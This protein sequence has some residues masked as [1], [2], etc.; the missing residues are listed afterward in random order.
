MLAEAPGY[1]SFDETSQEYFYEEMP[2]KYT[3]LSGV[4]G[5]VQDIVPESSVLIKTKVTEIDL[6]AATN[7]FA[8]GELVVFPNP[9]E[10]L[11]KY[12]LENF[13]KTTQGKI[14]YVGHNADL[15]IM[16]KANDLKISAVIAGSAD[17]ASFSYAKS[18]NLGLGVLSGFGKLETPD[19]IYRLINSVAYRHVFFHGDLGVLR[20]PM[21][22]NEGKLS[23]EKTQPVLKRKALPKVVKK[24]V[25][26]QVVQVLQ[27]PHFGKI[28]LID[29]VTGSSIFVRFGNELG[30]VEIDVPN[31][32]IIE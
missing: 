24:V 21:A 20:I 7:T 13:I 11:E 18:V 25:K 12:Y 16:N 31:F 23:E 32:Y 27:K 5:E 22:S 2:V 19:F 6:V 14:V 17:P 29:R 8:F 26:G 3:L 10:I 15:E 1:M 4:W 30:A 9:T 28:G